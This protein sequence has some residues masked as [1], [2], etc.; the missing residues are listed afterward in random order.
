MIKRMCLIIFMVLLTY[1]GTM[2]QSVSQE[3]PVI[4]K[5]KDQA[6][7]VHRIT[8]MRFEQLLPG[9][10]RETG[11][12]MWI[13]ACNEDNLDPVFTTMI[14]YKQWCP[15]T[16]IV[17]FYDL[18]PGK[19]VERLNISRTDFKDLYTN[20]WDASAWDT[21]GKESQ[22]DC[23]KRIVT[24]RDPKKIGI[25]TGKIQW[26]AGGLTIALK[27]KLDETLG[28]KY[29]ARMASAEEMSTLWLMTLLDEEIEFM[30]RAVAISHMII[31]EAFSSQV[32][33]PGY[34]T[35]EDLEYYY[36]QRTTDL[37]LDLA[38]SPHFSI[39]TRTPA[40][41]EKYGKDDKIIRPGDFMLCDVG[42]KYMHYHSDNAEWAYVLRQGETDVPESFKKMMSE[43]NKLQDVYCSGFVA[44]L[45]GNEML[46]NG[47]KKAR[48]QG[49]PNPKIF[50]HSVGYFLHEPGP[51]IGLPWEQVS[52]PGRG[53]VKL[54]CNSCYTAELS[55]SV[56][57]AKFGGKNFYFPMEQVVFVSEEGTVFLDGRQTNFHIVK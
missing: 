28:A 45:T 24:E 53:D 30:E 33:T 56:P 27:E 1:P 6:E 31:S 21:E 4:M 54:V 32:I 49:I 10:M 12:D 36:W 35:T 47:L 40:D 48:E 5:V 17:V 23:L 7:Y 52:N 29:V 2:A 18:G 25:N 41:I 57:L 19:G 50:S 13:I 14:P 26:A 22:W 9:I 34:T 43:C 51:L 39:R 38:F 11:F 8:K 16:Q 44:G 55:V 15:I 20:V 37:G 42:V 46:A 3:I